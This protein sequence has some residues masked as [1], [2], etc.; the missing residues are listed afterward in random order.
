MQRYKELTEEFIDSSNTKRYASIDYPYFP[1]RDSDQYIISKRTDRLELLADKYYNDHTLWWV[2]ARA[3]D[4]GK[5]TLNI[6]PGIR[7]RIPYPVNE[8]II[9]ELIR[10]R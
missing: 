8:L 9:D 5:G 4:L 10:D 3:N 6:P 2:I 1:Y 7:I